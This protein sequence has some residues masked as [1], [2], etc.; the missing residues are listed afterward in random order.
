MNI[1]TKA[2]AHEGGLCNL[3]KSLRLS[4]SQ[5]GNWQD[6]RRGTPKAWVIVLTGRYGH[7]PDIP[8]LERKRR[9]A[10]RQAVVSGAEGCE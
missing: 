6:E 3:A 9:L 7:L 10:K 8:A 4:S 5:V 1:L 2:I